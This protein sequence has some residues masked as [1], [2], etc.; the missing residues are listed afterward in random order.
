MP[1]RPIH[2]AVMAGE[3]SGDQLAAEVMTALQSRLGRNVRFSGVGGEA[4]SACGLISL[5]PMEELS[6]MGVTEVLPRIPK[7][8]GRISEAADHVISE[9]PDLLLTVD[10][11]DFSFR[12]HRKLRKAQGRDGPTRQIHFVAPTVWAWRAGRAKKI[13]GFLDGLLAM[14]PFEPGYFE[15]HGLDTRYVGHPVTER[16]PQGDGYGLKARLGIPSDRQVLLVLPGSR[17]G[18]LNYLLPVFEQVMMGLKEGGEAPVLLFPTL[19]KLANRLREEVADWPFP[20][21]ILDQEQDKWDSFAA[22]DAALAASGTIGLELAVAGV[23][24]VIAYK[25]NW[26]TGKMGRAL[27]KL[28]YALMANIILDD[29]AVPEFIQEYCKPEAITEALLG[30]LRSEEVRLAQRQKLEEV[31]ARLKPMGQSPAALAAD[32]ICDW[33]NLEKDKSDG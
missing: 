8:L 20:A 18:E 25:V 15:P 24:Q 12:V 14:L 23:P 2:I 32:A 5:F 6:V 27:V 13:A 22:A 26:L 33:L 17:N 21:H 7:L 29:M 31:V 16:V 28:D 11:P 1:D 4:M 9:K 19:P 10:A 30:M 3:P